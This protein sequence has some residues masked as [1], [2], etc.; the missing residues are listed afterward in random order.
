MDGSSFDEGHGDQQAVA[1]WGVWIPEGTLT[2]HGP[3]I[4]N[5][6]AELLFG[7]DKNTNNMAE[8]SAM[9][10]VL[11]WL[12]NSGYTGQAVIA[13]DSTYAANCT[14]GH[15]L[16]TSNVALAVSA[17]QWLQ[18]VSYT[19]SALEELD[20]RKGRLLELQTAF[21]QAGMGERPAQPMDHASLQKARRCDETM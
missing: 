16:P 21:H 17:Q 1:G 11:V 2:F 3:V 4:T 15:W 7:A 12:W 19:A 18:A 14:Q 6:S 9:V 13:Y 8:L 5:E 20:R 10:V